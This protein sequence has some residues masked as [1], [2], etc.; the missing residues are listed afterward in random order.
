MA[1]DS[2]KEKIVKFTFAFAIL[3]TVRRTTSFQTA[4]LVGLALNSA[5]LNEAREKLASD[6]EDECDKLAI[7]QNSD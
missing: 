1:T 2:T 3:E 6:D 7:S 4:V 5:D